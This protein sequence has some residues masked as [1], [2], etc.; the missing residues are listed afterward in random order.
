MS[1]ATELKDACDRV[2][3]AIAEIRDVGQNC[4]LGPVVREIQTSSSSTA[5]E[6]DRDGARYVTVRITYLELKP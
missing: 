4:E 3:R 2:A 6:F 5:A 1:R